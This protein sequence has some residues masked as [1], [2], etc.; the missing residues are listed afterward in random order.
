MAGKMF[1]LTYRNSWTVIPRQNIHTYFKAPPTPNLVGTKC[2]TS[3][4]HTCCN[5]SFHTGHKLP[6]IKS[7]QNW[8]LHNKKEA[9]YSVDLAQGLDALQHWWVRMVPGRIEPV[10]HRETQVVTVQFHKGT[11]KEGGP[12]HLACKGI[13]LKLEVPTQGC[14][15]ELQQL[16]NKR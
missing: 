9:Y 8:K 16:Q 4:A 1:F 6:L 3:S 14:H 7:L 2:K 5:Y 11:T 15:Q 10:M 13:C 12:V